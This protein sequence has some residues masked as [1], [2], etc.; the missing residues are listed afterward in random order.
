MNSIVFFWIVLASIFGGTIIG[1]F[2]R[3]RLPD[4]HLSIDSREVMKLGIGMISTMAD[5]VLGLLIGSAKGTF[6]TLS[7]GLMQTGAK[8]IL[9]DRTLAHYGPEAK[10]ARKMLRGKIN[11][12]AALL[13]GKKSAAELEKADQSEIGIEDIGDN[14]GQKV[15]QLSPRNDDQRRL[16]SQAL[17]LLAEISETRWFLGEHVGQTS[18]PMP[19]LVVLICWLTIVF[20][21]FGLFTSPNRTVIAVLFVC[22][23]SA[24]SSL[25]LILELDQPF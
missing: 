23:L 8:M 6:D 20:F 25:L 16:Q 2:L 11:S 1:M 10:E 12:V 4:H 17:Q 21:C 9:L 19:L 14:I 24:A 18:F 22:A 5:V 7:R 15:R 13:E 3:T